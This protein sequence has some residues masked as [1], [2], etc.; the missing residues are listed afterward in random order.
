MNYRGTIGFDTLPY[1]RKAMLSPTR[2]ARRE[3][4]MGPSGVSGQ[5]CAGTVDGQ[6][7]VPVA[8]LP[9][10][11]PIYCRVVKKSFCIVQG[12]CIVLGGVAF[13]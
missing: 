9:I 1:S 7:L 2:P 11:D 4:W 13:C 3:I 10:R 6:D 12:F 5:D 8:R